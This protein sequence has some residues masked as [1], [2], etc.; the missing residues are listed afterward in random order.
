MFLAPTCMLGRRL[1]TKFLRRSSGRKFIEGA[2]SVGHP[3]L[4]TYPGATV[5]IGAIDAP[6]RLILP[7]GGGRGKKGDQK[8]PGCYLAGAIWNIGRAVVVVLFLSRLVCGRAI[9]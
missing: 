6:Q 5:P 3:L 2:L 9:N 4:F 7:R 8:I 1:V